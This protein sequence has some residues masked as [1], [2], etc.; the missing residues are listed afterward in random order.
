MANGTPGP[1]GPPEETLIKAWQLRVLHGIS[2][3]DIA[4]ELDVSPRTV[5]RYVKLGRELLEQL[6]YLDRQ[7]GE[8]DRNAVREDS[9]AVMDMVRSWMVEYK[10]QGGDPVQAALVVI[11]A[12]E[13]KAK[14]LGEQALARLEVGPTA[15][16]AV[17]SKDMQRTIDA[18]RAVR[19]STS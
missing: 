2:P 11:K 15:P 6:E 1:D 16:P 5:K 7:R 3:A 18:Y 8:L 19:G 17:P 13:R 9:A 14:A 4:V 10:D 12:E